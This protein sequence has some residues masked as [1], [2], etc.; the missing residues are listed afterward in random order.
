MRILIADDQEDILAGF[1]GLLREEGHEVETA[2]NGQEALEKITVLSQ[3]GRLP[4]FI[5]SDDNMP[6]MGGL[7][8]ITAARAR[9]INVEFAIFSSGVVPERW[10]KY[11]ALGAKKL[12]IKPALL[13]EF[14]SILPKVSSK[15]AGGP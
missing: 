11:E 5:I 3:E 14:L 2:I 13:D 15:R 9:E 8:W 10:E 6:R 1:G 4:D 7:E 12:L